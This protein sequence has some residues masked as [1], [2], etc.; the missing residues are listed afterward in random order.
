VNDAE[1]FLT[2]WSRRKQAAAVGAREPSKPRTAAG[3]LSETLDASVPL[4]ET[5]PPF[6]PASLP[7]I[8]SIGAASDVRAFLAAGVPADLTRAALRR[9]W[10]SDPAIRDFIG[11]SENSWDF[12][13][14]G[15]MPGFG[16]IS[17]EEIRRLVTLIMGEPE[18][19][20]AVQHRPVRFS[21]PYQV[22]QHIGESMADGEMETVQKPVQVQGE[23]ISR[24]DCDIADTKSGNMQGGR[25]AATLQTQRIQ[26][27]PR[28]PLRRGRHGGA[29]PE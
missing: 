29:L 22:M 18:A 25:I 16:P 27:E 3:G 14:A 7:S 11:L 1:D 20:A 10:S 4:G 9:A 6:D 2:R 24:R 15:A 8:K 28:L 23:N 19:K 17:Q 5:P 12:N 26:P 13:A 21:E